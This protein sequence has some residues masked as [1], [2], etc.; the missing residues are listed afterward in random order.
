M[1]SW[2]GVCIAVCKWCNA[3]GLGQYALVTCRQRSLC[4]TLSPSRSSFRAPLFTLQK[5]ATSGRSK[6]DEGRE[7]QTA[8]SPPSS[9]LRV[10]RKDGDSGRQSEHAW[11]Q[12]CSAR[13][14]SS[15]PFPLTDLRTEVLPE[16]GLVVLDAV[17]PHPLPAIVVDDG[18]FVLGGDAESV[19]VEL[20]RGDGHGAGSVMGPLLRSR[21]PATLPHPLSLV[22]QM[23]HARLGGRL[24]ATLAPPNLCLSR[25]ML[26]EL[27]RRRRG[28]D[29]HGDG[30]A[31]A[32]PL[33]GELDV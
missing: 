1:S 16:E 31:L 33:Q 18:L 25:E 17:L 11:S 9:R 30:F 19:D 15:L 26:V 7:E 21:G 5:P 3:E 29:R 14:C 4:V 28:E 24:C 27:L 20:A 8:H 22:L 2:S 23:L 13:L 12:T 6:G 10:R 32:S